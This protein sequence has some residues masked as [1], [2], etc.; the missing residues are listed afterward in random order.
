MLRSAEEKIGPAG[1]DD[2]A[3]WELEIRLLRQE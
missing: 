1:P 2:H 3:G